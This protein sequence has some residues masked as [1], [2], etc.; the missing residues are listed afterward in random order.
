MVLHSQ[1]ILHHGLANHPRQQTVYVVNKIRVD[2]FR[3]TDLV[4][5]SV[6]PLR[7]QPPEWILT[8]VPESGAQLFVLSKM[9][10]QA[11]LNLAIVR[12]H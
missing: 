4:L 7:G 10:H 8:W 9:C 2:C 5:W 6:K 3:A 11:K 1:L 12:G